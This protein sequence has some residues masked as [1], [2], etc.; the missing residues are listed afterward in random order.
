MAEK[1][2]KK[3]VEH[4]ARLA[5]LELTEQEVARYA[6]ELSAILGYISQLEE[7]DAENAAITSQVTGLS[8]VLREDLV[9]AWANPE[10]LAALAPEHQDGLVK[11]KAVFDA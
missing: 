1:I 8:N 6:K 9:D 4:I 2:S 10:E 3:E 11:V 5:R 7:V